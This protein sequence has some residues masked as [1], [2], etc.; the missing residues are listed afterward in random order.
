MEPRKTFNQL[1]NEYQRS[2]VYSRGAST[3]QTRIDDARRAVVDEYERFAGKGAA[4]EE[5]SHDA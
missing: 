5:P 3:N 4:D 2:M 1:L